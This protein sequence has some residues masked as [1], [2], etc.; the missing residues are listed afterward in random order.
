MKNGA[1]I[2]PANSARPAILP[3]ISGSNESTTA[4]ISKSRRMSVPLFIKR[5]LLCALRDWR[6]GD[7]PLSRCWVLVP[8]G[9]FSSGN[10]NFLP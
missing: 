3:G 4:H 10:S 7:P 2:R 5:R 6:Q 8:I 9:R 1:P